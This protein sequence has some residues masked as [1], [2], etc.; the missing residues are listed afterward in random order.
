MQNNY[1]VYH[2]NCLTG[3]NKVWGEKE[4]DRLWYVL[5]GR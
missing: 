2:L 5:R 3:E 1:N 4:R